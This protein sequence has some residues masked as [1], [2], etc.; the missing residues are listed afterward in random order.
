MIVCTWRSVFTNT[1]VGAN[2][3]NLQTEHSKETE[4]SGVNLFNSAT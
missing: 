3:K 2:L 4:Y 1:G